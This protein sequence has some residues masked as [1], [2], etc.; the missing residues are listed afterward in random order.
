MKKTV[1]LSLAI[2]L[3]SVTGF[4]EQTDLKC[5][6]GDGLATLS[7]RLFKNQGGIHKA[8]QQIDGC[9]T[10]ISITASLIESDAA[11]GTRLVYSLF[12]SSIDE[13]KKQICNYTNVAVDYK[14]E[15]HQRSI[16]CK[17]R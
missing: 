3:I 16:F 4:S 11:S 12:S 8:S 7:E 13:N 15:A 2:L 14:S 6:N 1:V 17:Y 5:Y 10:S 9:P